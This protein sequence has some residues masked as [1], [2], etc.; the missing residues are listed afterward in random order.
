MPVKALFFFSA[1]NICLNVAMPTDFAELAVGDLHRFRFF[2]EAPAACRTRFAL[3]P[4]CAA[5][6]AGSQCGRVAVLA[7]CTVRGIFCA[8]ILVQRPNDLVIREAVHKDGA[9]MIEVQAAITVTNAVPGLA[10]C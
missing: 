2:D 10:F 9:A 7:A 8:P 4:Y 5:F 3:E 6:R 1:V